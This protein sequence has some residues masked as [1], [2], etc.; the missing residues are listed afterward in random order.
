MSF[1]KMNLYYWRKAICRVIIMYEIFGLNASKKNVQN[2][3]F[4]CGQTLGQS[5]MCQIRS[6]FLLKKFSLEFFEWSNLQKGHFDSNCQINQMK[7]NQIEQV[8]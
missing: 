3:E 2:K 1:L 6:F 4:F 7:K 5:Q 8:L